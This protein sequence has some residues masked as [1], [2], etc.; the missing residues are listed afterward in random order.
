MNDIPDTPTML[1]TA[2][3][4]TARMQHILEL[5]PSCCESRFVAATFI[6]DLTEIFSSP[7][8]QALIASDDSYCILS[9]YFLWDAT[10]QG[11]KY[12]SHLHQELWKEP[13]YRKP[14]VNFYATHT[15]S[16]GTWHGN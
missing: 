10:A 13:S 14:F 2:P 3:Q 16:E 5:V 15:S 9:S 7:D 6:S 11:H 4:L 1:H 12:W 8:V